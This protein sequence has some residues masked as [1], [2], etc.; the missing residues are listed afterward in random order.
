KKRGKRKPPVHVKKA[1]I[2]KSA[3]KKSA[4][5]PRVRK[6][7]RPG[8][9]VAPKRGPRKASQKPRDTRPPTAKR[10]RSPAA[11]EQPKSTR[12]AS[13][14]VHA[15]MDESVVVNTLAKVDVT[16]SREAIKKALGATAAG[17]SAVVE[18]DRKILV[19]IV[20]KINFSISPDE[21][22]VEIDVPAPGKPKALSF[23]VKATDLGDGEVWISFR[24]GGV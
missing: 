7:A 10:G 1:A 5:K 15:A 19:R 3:V 8:K 13:V 20:P 11:G 16:V 12:T 22:A 18:L 4:K 23:S 9:G 14:N 24:Q 6:A 2:K 17:D 21:S